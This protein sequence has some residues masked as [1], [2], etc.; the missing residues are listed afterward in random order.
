MKNS[1]QQTLTMRFHNL[2][3]KGYFEGWFYK[4]VSPDEKTVLCFIPGVSVN[5]QKASPF[6]QVNLARKIGDAWQQ[7]TDW[8]DETIFHAQDEPFHLKAGSSAF[9]RDGLAAVFKGERLHI[10]GQLE[11]AGL[12][13]PPATR[14]MPTIMGPFS[15]LPGMECIHSVISL[16]HAVTGSVN[17]NG[18]SV[19]F[20]G[21]KGYIEKDWGSSFPKRYVWLQTNHFKREGSLFFSW[22]DIPALGMSFPGYIAHLYYGGQHYR[23]ATYTRG[24]CRIDFQDEGVDIVLTNRDSELKIK[25][26]RPLGG[27]LIAPHLGEMRHAIKEGLYGDVSF[28]LKRKGQQ[29]DICDQSEVVGVEIVLEKEERQRE[30]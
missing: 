15:Y 9:S 3:R 26:S 6:I 27:E 23:Y 8:A 17:I 13:P 10:T 7:T 12:T 25:A 30:G 16:T 18:E 19:D 11:F 2:P 21:G 29:G 5:N 20:S 1:K 22:A 14:L 4:Q 28:C 24:T